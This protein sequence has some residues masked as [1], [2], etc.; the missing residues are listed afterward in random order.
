MR[1]V[2]FSAVSAWEATSGIRRRIVSVNF[3]GR[4]LP[5]GKL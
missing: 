1:C 2:P 5:L 3:S 4:I